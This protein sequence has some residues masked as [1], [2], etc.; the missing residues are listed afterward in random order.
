MRWLKGSLAGV[1]AAVVLLGAPSVASAAMVTYSVPI[2]WSGSDDNDLND[3]DHLYMYAWKITDSALIGKNITGAVL[4]FEN[5]V[6]WNRSDNVLYVDLLDSVKG[7]T[8]VTGQQSPAGGNVAGWGTSTN[9]VSTFQDNSSDS[10]S[11]GDS[12]TTGSFSS[13]AG[14]IVPSGVTALT[15]KTFLGMGSAPSSGIDVG[16]TYNGTSTVSKGEVDPAGWAHSGAG[17]ASGN[18]ATANYMTVNGVSNT[19]V[20]NYTY[21]FQNNATNGYELNALM[22]AINNGGDFAI[23]LDPDCHYFN[24]GIT[25]TLT[26]SDFGGSSAVPE[27]ASMVLLGTGLLVAGRYRR[28][29]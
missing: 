15:S 23:G 29:K 10:V 26:Y 7:P 24:T 25:L 9:S 22:A 4:T 13:T 16:K 11:N 21:T 19:A 14:W 3:L 2:D 27:P 1:G 8:T 20:Y 18:P 6:N 5:L 17:G 12:F 28:K